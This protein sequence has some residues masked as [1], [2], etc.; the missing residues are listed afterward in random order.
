M[1]RPPELVP[2]AI[3]EIVKLWMT[4]SAWPNS[5]PLVAPVFC[6]RP[7]TQDLDRR[8]ALGCDAFDRR[9][10][11]FNPVGSSGPG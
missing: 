7:L 6:D 4:R 5:A 8:R 2:T 9:T 10:G 11:Y 1:T 3:A